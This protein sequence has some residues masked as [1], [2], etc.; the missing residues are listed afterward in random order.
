ME[1]PGR[2][3]SGLDAE[4]WRYRF[5]LIVTALA[6]LGETTVAVRDALHPRPGIAMPWESTFG[7]L[8][9]AALLV[10]LLMRRV[11]LRA[12]DLLVTLIVSVVLVIELLESFQQAA[13][14]RLRLYF[15]AL[16]VILSVVT[17]LPVRAALAWVGTIMAALV[18]LVLTRPGPVDATLLIEMG[19]V[20]LLILHLAFFGRQ[21]SN[22]RLEGQQYRQL[23]FTDPLTGLDNRR[24]MYDHLEAAFR[25]LRRG[26]PFAVVLLDL[27]HFKAINDQYG[28]GTGDQVLQQVARILQGGLR[29]DDHVARWGGEEFLLVLNDVS[30]EQ[31]GRTTARLW[32]A[33]REARTGALPRFTASFGVATARPEDGVSSLLQRADVRLY[34]AKA[35]GRDR[36]QLGAPQGA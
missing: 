20:V 28:H 19:V 1:R 3:T 16:F 29:E 10:T 12:L 33:V 14:P 36:W 17:N 25:N 6:C 5:Y 31:A 30:E 27:D 32:H 35:L 23:A 8:F 7:A 26:T 24:A 34:E 4:G 18:T 15:I 13:P 22:E 21:V 9:C 2:R 11:P